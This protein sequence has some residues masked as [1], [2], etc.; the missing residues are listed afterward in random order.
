MLHDVRARLA[1]VGVRAPIV[2]GA[3]CQVDHFGYCISGQMHRR[4]G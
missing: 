4:R 2:G 3:S 1:L